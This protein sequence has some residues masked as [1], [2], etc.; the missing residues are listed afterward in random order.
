VEVKKQIWGGKFR[1]EGY[2][3]SRV[4]KCGKEEVITKYVKAEGTEKR[5]NKCTGGSW[6][7]SDISNKIFR[8][9]LRKLNLTHK[10]EHIC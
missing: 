2:F 9:P 1:R 4:S 5:I 6:N 7:Y 3:V 10:I 8:Y